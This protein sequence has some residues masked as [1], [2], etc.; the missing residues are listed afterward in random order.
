MNLKKIR[1]F[2]FGGSTVP[3]REQP[4]VR[5]HLAKGAAPRDIDMNGDIMN[6]QMY[7][8]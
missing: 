1:S 7:G 8:E 6:G 4:V 3:L 2:F 5:Q